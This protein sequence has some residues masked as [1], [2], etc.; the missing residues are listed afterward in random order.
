MTDGYAAYP[1][2]PGTNMYIV[3]KLEIM[4][5]D[6]SIVDDRCLADACAR[7]DYRHRRDEAARPRSVPTRRLTR[8]DE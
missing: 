5:D 4:V 1:A 7:P 8:V 2:G 6:R 3:A